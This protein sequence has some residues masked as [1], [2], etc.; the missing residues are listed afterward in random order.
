MSKNQE[1]LTGVTER[2]VEVRDKTY[3]TTT[4]ILVSVN[5][6]VDDKPVETDESKGHTMI[7][8]G[9]GPLFYSCMNFYSLRQIEISWHLARHNTQQEPL[10]DWKMGCLEF[11]CGGVV[12]TTM[13]GYEGGEHVA[14]TWLDD[15]M[16][17]G[18]SRKWALWL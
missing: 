4:T 10:E 9:R 8:S 5:E 2:A 13:G 7:A 18:C 16:W 15:D 11:I 17:Y 3:W 6:E 12:N 1:W 14:N